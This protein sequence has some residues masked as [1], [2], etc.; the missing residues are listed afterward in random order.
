MSTLTKFELKKIAG[1][2]NIIAAAIVMAVFLGFMIVTLIQPMSSVLDSGEE[3]DGPA[4]IPVERNKVHAVA[5]PLTTQKISELIAEYQKLYGDPKNRTENNYLSDAAFGK[6]SRYAGI[7]RLIG[8]S[9]SP[10]NAFDGEAIRK[11]SPEDGS[12]FYANRM[13][14][15]SSFL[16]LYSAA[17]SYTDAQK[18]ELLSLNEKIT[19]PFLY[20]YTDGWYALMRVIAS[21]AAMLT[22]AVCVCISPVFASEYETGSDSILLTAKYGR[23][24]VI[25]AKLR[26]SFLFSTGLYFSAVLLY[27]LIHLCIF[28]GYG[29]NCPIQA[30]D[31]YWFSPYPVT[32]LQA[33]L[34]SVLLGY[35]ACTA[36]TAATL[37]LSARLKTSFAAIVFA[38]G[39][40]LFPFA[41]DVKKLPRALGY[42]WYLFP[43]KIMDGD[44]IFRGNQL[45][46]LYD[47]FGHLVLQPYVMAGAALIFS[48]VFSIAAYRTFRRHQVA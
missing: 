28:G 41:V 4:S 11:I 33:Y 16:T 6:W 30:Q 29:W 42:L 43:I 26:A 37:F 19:V 34:V 38:A 24:K 48:A 7:Q 22:L 27:T 12:G 5:G 17:G 31:A 25:R 20:D 45:Y 3:V 40:F 8:R 23:N 44:G 32:F 39:L 47:V 36:V 9:F 35:L 10:A 13:K 14:G 18:A 21:L 1:R 46:E 2:K 15:V